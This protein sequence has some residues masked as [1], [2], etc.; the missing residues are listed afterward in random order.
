M[1]F[2]KGRM[3]SIGVAAA[4]LALIAVQAVAFSQTGKDEDAFKPAAAANE[5]STVMSSDLADESTATQD[6][7]SEEPSSTPLEATSSAAKPAI[8]GASVGD[9]EGD[10]SSEGETEDDD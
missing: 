8:T 5:S 1:N 10:D 2:L 4:V 6:L 3:T 9:D 7:V